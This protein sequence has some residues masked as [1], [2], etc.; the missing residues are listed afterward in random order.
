MKV[1]A[2]PS[3]WGTPWKTIYI[4]NPNNGCQINNSERLKEG[5]T[6]SELSWD[7]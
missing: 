1:P 6:N 5:Y 3:G 2:G 4:M 7:S